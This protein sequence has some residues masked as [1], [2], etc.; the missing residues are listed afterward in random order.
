MNQDIMQAR[1]LAEAAKSSGRIEAKQL[2]LEAAENYA[3]AAKLSN[4]PYYLN[5]ATLLYQKAI[6]PD[7]INNRPLTKFKD[8]GGLQDIK[9]EIRLKI[10]EPLLRPDAF[11]YFGKKPGGGILMYGPPG[12]GKSLIAEAAAGEADVAFY[13]IKPS[14]IKDKY[15]GESEKNISRLFESA[16]K[17]VSIVFFDEFEALG[18]ER[19]LG[20]IH[21]KN[22]VS[23]LLTEMDGFGNKDKKILLIGATNEPWSID[24]ALRRHG[25]FGTMIFIPPPDF[26]S[27]ISIFQLNLRNRPVS[28]DIDI[29]RLA[30]MSEHYSGADIVSVCETAT[31]IALKD[32]INS[33]HNRKITMQDITTAINNKKSTIVPWFKLAIE[34]IKKQGDEQSYPELF[35]YAKLLR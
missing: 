5:E 15:V 28:S 26:I 30:D 18:G 4:N 6:E 32:F 22:L 9:E 8:I 24:L 17:D 35:N 21:D 16:K 7:K 13:H 23:Q 25:R 33:N 31:D 19:S 27:R 1:L 3:R 14:D 11:R 10:I 2:Y 34:M 29:F 20:S 12:C